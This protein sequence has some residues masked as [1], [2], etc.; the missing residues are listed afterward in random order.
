M[1][2]SQRKLANGRIAVAEAQPF[3]EITEM[4]KGGEAAHADAIKAEIDLRQR[5][6]A[7]T[8]AQAP[9]PI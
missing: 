1:V 7:E 4:E 5:D 8:L 2:D 3:Y 6:L 9:A